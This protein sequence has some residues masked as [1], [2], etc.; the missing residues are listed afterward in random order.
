MEKRLA[1]RDAI[2]GGAWDKFKE[3]SIRWG[4][5][6]QF[7]PTHSNGQYG[8]TGRPSVTYMKT[9]IGHVKMAESC[10]RRACTLAPPGKY[11]RTIVRGGHKWVSNNYSGHDPHGPQRCTDKW[12]LDSWFF[13][14]E[15]NAM[16]NV[17]VRDL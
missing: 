2:W 14:S 9:I 6:L 16:W 1:S 4:P 8:V 3:L 5:V 11:G 17:I 13:I 7:P 12:V 10:I 15:D